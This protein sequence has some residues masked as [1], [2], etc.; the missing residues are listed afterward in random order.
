MLVCSRCPGVGEIVKVGSAVKNLK[1]R[2]WV[3]PSFSGWGTWRTYAICPATDVINIP[4]DIPLVSAATL[5]VNPCTAYRLLKDFETLTT[6]DVII[7]NGANSGVGQA[8][9]QIA[10]AMNIKTIN[11]V[12]NRPNLDELVKTL[13]DLGAT[14]VVTD[15]YLRTPD[16]QAMLKM[17]AK[18][19]KLALNCVGGKS[20]ADLLKC[21]SNEG[22]MVTYGG[23]SRQPL[24]V[25]AGPLIFS[26]I[27]LRGFWMTRWNTVNREKP[28]MAEMWEF[29]VA[30]VRNGKL[31]PPTHR[32][33]NFDQV[34]DGVVKSMQ[35]MTSE[36][37]ILRL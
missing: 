29:L 34:Q 12:R 15:E 8:V 27:R 1:V 14:H 31:K 9:I 35:P 33:V 7:Q 25:P 37:Q 30:L 28:E 36:K 13:T 21:I 22:S 16:M 10:S 24:M 20:S 19:P 26:D 32:L 5:S 18:K 11:V 23:M 3:I 4:N 17:L 2:D 6:N